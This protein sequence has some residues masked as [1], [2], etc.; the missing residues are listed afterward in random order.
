MLVECLT[1]SSKCQTYH[2]G[3]CLSP[4][5]SPV[6]CTKRCWTLFVTT[7]S[8]ARK[9]LD[10]MSLMCSLHRGQSESCL[11]RPDSHTY[12]PPDARKSVDLHP[13]E[14]ADDSVL[15]V[16]TCMHALCLPSIRVSNQKHNPSKK[17]IIFSIILG[18]F[19]LSLFWK[20][21]RQCLCHDIP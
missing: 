4:I 10:G 15:L 12:L 7:Q 9:R 8:L 6:Y 20:I 21:M 14:E 1:V 3:E 16:D 18:L 19:S 2:E 11:V 17:Q 13:V 5:H